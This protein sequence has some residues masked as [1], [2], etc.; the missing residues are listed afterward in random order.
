M[1]VRLQSILKIGDISEVLEQVNLYM[2]FYFI[3]SLQINSL[4]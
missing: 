2:L 3:S 1:R 4:N